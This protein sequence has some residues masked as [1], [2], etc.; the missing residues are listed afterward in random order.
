LEVLQGF[1]DSVAEL[2]DGE[3]APVSRCVARRFAEGFA[4]AVKHDQARSPG[5]IAS[6]YAK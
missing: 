6:V 3:D 4:R 5:H 1:A 2:R